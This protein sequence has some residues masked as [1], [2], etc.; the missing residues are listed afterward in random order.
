MNEKC[1]VRV[2]QSAYLMLL[3]DDDGVRLP[4]SETGELPHPTHLR[5]TATRSA[6][7]GEDPS[8]KQEDTNLNI[9]CASNQGL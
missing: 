4:K 9:G 2:K 7:L 8:A 6:Q 5:V 3:K 1:S